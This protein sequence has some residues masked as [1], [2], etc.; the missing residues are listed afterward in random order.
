MSVTVVPFGEAHIEP[1]AALLAARHRQDRTWVPEL[2]SQFEDPAASAAVLH[3]LCAQDGKEGVAALH[4]GSLVGF[5]LGTAELGSPAGT[6]A[7]MMRPRSAEIPYDGFA[8]DR[9]DSKLYRSM[10]ATL[11]AGWLSQGLTTHYISIPANRDTAE[12]WSDLGFGRLIEMGVRDTEPSAATPLTRDHD[13][14]VRRATAADEEA[15]QTLATEM[16]RAWSSPPAFIPFLPET[17]AARRQFIAE[18]L[19]D[20]ACPHWLACAEGR[21]VGMHVFTEPASAHWHVSTLQSP[22]Q[23]VYLFLASTMPE[24]LSRGV[25]AALLAQTIAW[26]REAGYPRCAAHYVTA[27]RAAPFW[28][29][30]GFRP[31]SHWLSRS[32][33]ERALWARGQ[34]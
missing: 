6:W 15:I 4:D 33:D 9:D 8:A 13:F 34:A 23:S 29:G 18:M 22:P 10:Y 21:V 26:A 24:E 5:M 11:A 19:A 25:G 2:P 27:T 12:T 3:E 16:L 28:R 31:A 32:I 1:A 30:L 14:E 20:L 17:A 7:G